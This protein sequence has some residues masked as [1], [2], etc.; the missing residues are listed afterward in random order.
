MEKKYWVCMILLPA[1]VSRRKAAILK[2]KQLFAFTS[3][4]V[5]GF[6]IYYNW[7]GLLKKLI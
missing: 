1:G 5:P 4:K 2:E 6:R 7:K 3:W